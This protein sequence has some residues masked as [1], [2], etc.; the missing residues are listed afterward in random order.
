MENLTAKQKI[1]ARVIQKDIAVTKFPFKETGD[2]RG[3]PQG[4]V[5]HTIR[6]LLE[7]G[8]IRKFSAILRHQ[9]A[10]YKKNALVVWSVPAGQVQETGKRFASFPFI[11]HCYE[12]KPAF[13]NK[14]N[15]FTML[16]SNDK[17]FSSFISE[18]TAATGIHDY[19]ILESVQEYKKTSPEYFK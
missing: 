3:W 10:G 12:R 13:E 15:I 16:H 1:V 9:K 2:F 7:K 18:M 5:L 14:Y 8:F 6:Q 4:E 19:R 11:S 17:K